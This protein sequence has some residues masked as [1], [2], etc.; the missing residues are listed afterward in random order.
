MERDYRGG[1]RNQPHYNVLYWTQQLNGA[2]KGERKPRRKEG[3]GLNLS[4][5]VA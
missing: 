3:Y 1:M 5:Y 2:L 4:T